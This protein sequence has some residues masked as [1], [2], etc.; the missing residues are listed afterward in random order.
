MD[1]THPSITG[2]GKVTILGHEYSFA[3]RYFPGQ[4]LTISE[5]EAGAF[6]AILA[7]NLRNNFSS[8]IRAKREEL[9]IG[10]DDPLPEGE[11]QALLDAFDEYQRSYAF[12]KVKPRVALDPVQALAEKLAREAISTQ[13][14]KRGKA[15]KDYEESWIDEKVAL[16]LEKN[17]QLRAEA[18]RRIAAAQSAAEVA[19]DL[20]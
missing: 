15:L 7:E 12:G 2:R 14:R 9:G 8:K 16:V 3:L 13:L 10:P 20:E 4:V 5:G 1:S 18:S 17:P 6:N 19:F 11:Q